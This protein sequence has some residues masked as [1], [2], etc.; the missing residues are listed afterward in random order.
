MRADVDAAGVV[1]EKVGVVGEAV[2]AARVDGVV[3]V[4]VSVVAASVV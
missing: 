3:V 1:A 4:N 2:V